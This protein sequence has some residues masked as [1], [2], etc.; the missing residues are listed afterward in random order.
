MALFFLIFTCL[1]ANAESIRFWAALPQSEHVQML[2]LVNRYNQKHS[3]VPVEYRNFQNP[4]ELLQALNQKEVPDLAMINCTWIGQ[5]KSRLILADDVLAR[6]GAMVRAVAQADTFKPIWT[7]CMAEGKVVA[8]PFSAQTA[9]LVMNP[10]HFKKIPKIS[11][12][13]Q[14]QK[15]GLFLNKGPV[16]VTPVILPF[17]WE[18]PEIGGLWTSFALALS[19][20]PKRKNSKDP[21]HP[22]NLHDETAA[23]NFWWNWVNRSKISSMQVPPVSDGFIHGAVWILLPREL[24]MVKEKSVVQTLPKGKK[25]WA[26][27]DVE[28]LAFFDPRTSWDFA[29][30]LTDYPQMKFW[31][32]NTPTVPVNKQVYLSPDYLREIDAYR[33]WMRMYIAS[34]NQAS[35]SSEFSFP[36]LEEV[37]KLVV[38]SLQNEVTVQEGALRIHQSL[39]GN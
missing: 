26:F 10:R 37:G 12:V 25:P 7:S 6:A 17:H 22:F 28:A 30:Y 38:K 14:L 8:I 34:V 23:M 19:T 18:K 24:D 27:L 4:H 29:N 32:L 5:L 35:G 21:S 13:T 11:T 36:Q 31:A 16:N 9:A 3:A 15:I 33:P 2:D 20:E 1:Q 39:F